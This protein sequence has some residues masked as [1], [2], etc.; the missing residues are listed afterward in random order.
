MKTKNKMGGFKILKS[1]QSHFCGS[2]QWEGIAAIPAIDL[3]VANPGC[4]ELATC[5]TL[6]TCNDWKRISLMMMM[7]MMMMEMKMNLE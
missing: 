7:M 1:S 3:E 5:F 2:I 4:H 6:E